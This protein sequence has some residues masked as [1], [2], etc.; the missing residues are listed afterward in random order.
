MKR[1][2]LFTTILTAV[3]VLVLPFVGGGGP[4]IQSSVGSATADETGLPIFASS[5]TALRTT[6]APA[7]LTVAASVAALH[8]S[9][10]VI[11][12]QTAAT[13]A[14]LSHDTEHL[15]QKPVPIPPPPVVTVAA[16]AAAQRAAGSYTPAQRQAARAAAGQ[17]CPGG[18]GGGGSAPGGSD[19]QGVSGTT[20]GDIQA[21]A[22]LY[23]AIRVANCLDPVPSSN[24]RYDSCME[25]RLYWMAEDPSAD[26]GNTWGHAGVQSLAPGPD[27]QLYSAE[28]PSRGCD[29]NLAGGSGNSGATVAQKWWDS[30]AHRL[31]L[32]KPSYTGSTAGVCIY[33]AMTHGGL[34]N[35]SSS[36]TRAAARWAAC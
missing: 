3:L 26:P 6:T 16:Q 32:Y 25:Q 34:P 29:G 17:S 20:S 1:F 2:A 8:S 33:F 11:A 19:G 13:T 28:V 21:F 5:P 31:A 15:A 22:S 10:A 14:V 36:F 9:G 18:G 7:G 35:E 12:A 4:A 30:M 27:G 23:N 24:F